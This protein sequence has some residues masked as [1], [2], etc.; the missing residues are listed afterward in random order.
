MNI[1]IAAFKQINFVGAIAR[2]SMAD[3]TEQQEHSR[4][5]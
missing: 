1:P 2:G 3:S 4:T 5:A